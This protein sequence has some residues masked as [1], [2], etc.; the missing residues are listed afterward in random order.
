MAAAAAGRTVGVTV[1]VPRETRSRSR[2]PPSGDD[3]GGYDIGWGAASAVAAV[4]VVAGVTV[5]VVA[6]VASPALVRQAVGVAVLAVV[7]YATFAVWMWGWVRADRRVPSAV[8]PPSARTVGAADLS[9][10]RE[11]RVLAA[12]VAVR[13]DRGALAQLADVCAHTRVPQGAVSAA[14]LAARHLDDSDAEVSFA[15]RRTADAAVTALAAALSDAESDAVGAGFRVAVETRTAD[16][17][18]AELRHTVRRHRRST[19]DDV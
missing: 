1:D 3:R 14:R 5:N 9:R 15:A 7:V 16:L 11:S 19:A 2:R 6:G 8:L 4:A 18:A 10:V 13:R 17:R 12:T